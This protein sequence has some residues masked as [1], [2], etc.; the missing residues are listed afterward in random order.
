MHYS[1]KLKR[2]NK[3]VA[4]ELEALRRELRAVRGY[5]TS[6]KFHDDTT[7]QVR[8]VLARLQA[9]EDDALAE[10]FDYEC[11]AGLVDKVPE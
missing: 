7:V 1:E 5:L 8:D 6:A 10:R 9:A 3:A 11:D 2:E 4:I